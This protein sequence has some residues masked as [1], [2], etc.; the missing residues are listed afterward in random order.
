VQRQITPANSWEPSAQDALRDDIFDKAASR[1]NE[2]LTTGD[3][4]DYFVPSKSE[5]SAMSFQSPMHLPYG[6]SE[7]TWEQFWGPNPDL[8]MERRSLLP[9]YVTAEYNQWDRNP[10]ENGL[11]KS[12][13]KPKNPWVEDEERDLD[14]GTGASSAR[15]N[16]VKTLGI[17][18]YYSFAQKSNPTAYGADPIVNSSQGSMPPI[19][20]AYT[21]KRIK[22]N[23]VPDYIPP[24]QGSTQNP[25]VAP[26]MFLPAQ[27][28]NP[29]QPGSWGQGKG[30][31]SGFVND[32]GSISVNPMEGPRLRKNLDNWEQWGL[33]NGGYVSSGADSTVNDWQRGGRYRINL[34]QGGQEPIFSGALIN[35]GPSLD[36]TPMLGGRIKFP[37]NFDTVLSGGLLTGGQNY[38]GVASFDG[39]RG[40][41]PTEFEQYASGGLQGGVYT[42]LDTNPN[43][44]G[45]PSMRLNFETVLAGGITSGGLSGAETNDPI[46]GIKLPHSCGV[47]QHLPIP[48]MPT[49]YYGGEETQGENVPARP[50]MT[51]AWSSPALSIPGTSP[52]SGGPSASYISPD[53][54]VTKPNTTLNEVQSYDDTPDPVLQMAARSPLGARALL[55]FTKDNLDDLTF[56]RP[57]L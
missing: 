13:A 35:N 1:G 6:N 36:L 27:S 9:T 43:A 16:D 29:Y 2:G 25:A 19:L 37:I 39:S 30:S 14:W 33:A 28:R 50:R 56:E 26:E 54:F 48:G 10:Y 52:A 17:N 24:P 12:F 44:G 15:S 18:R 42:G 20:L 55:N 32:Y 45:R 47:A 49:S 8:L 51:G 53:V 21:G 41:R 31:G 7:R 57:C 40:R 11:Q 3:D 4:A 38:S 46:G 22:D 23:V 5:P 34:T